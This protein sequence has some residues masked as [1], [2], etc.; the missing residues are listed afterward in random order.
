M[1]NINF[2]IDLGTTNSGIGLY[3]DGKVTVLKNPVGFRETLP[4]VVSF[5]GERILIGD[6]ANEQLFSNP[7]NVFSSF[8]RK[9]GT[10][11][12]YFVKALNKD[13]TPVELSTY[14]L[15]E[16][17]NFSINSGVDS[18]VI[19]IPASFDTIQSNATKTAGYQSGLS[20]VVLLQ[21][22]IAACLAYANENELN[23]TEEKKWLVYDFGGGTFDVAIVKVNERELKVLDNK[24]NNFLGG[25]DLDLKIM[26]DVVIP[27]LSQLT[28]IENLSDK[29][30]SATESEFLKLGK[31]LLYQ[32]EEIK[33]E[34]SLKKEAWL[35]VN[36]HELGINQELKITREEINKIIEPVY[37]ESFVLL[38]ELLDDN[39][40]LFSD[41]ERI[42][43]VGG[44]TYIPFIRDSLL[45]STGITIDSSIDPTTAVILGATYYAGNKPK[46]K[47]ITED[48]K[49]GLKTELSI[50][51]SYENLTKDE[52]ELIAFKTESPFEGFYRVV[53]SD[54]GF[55]SGMIK[56]SNHANEFV[57]LLTKQNN[58]FKLSIFDADQKSVY[59]NSEI[60]ISHGFYNVNG[61]PLPNDIC[62]E[63]DEEKETYLELIFKKN[64]IL[65]LKKTIYKTFSKSIAKGSDDKVVIN[66]VE[67]RA[68]SLPGANLNIGYVEISGKDL[69]DDLI[70][71]TDIELSFKISE[72]R[73][74]SVEIFIPSS[75]QE[76]IETF[77]PKYQNEIGSDKLISELNKGLNIVDEQIREFED[78]EDY[79]QLAFLTKIKDELGDVKGSALLF[80][81]GI[82]TD[83]KY[84]L[85]EKKRKLL[86][87]VDK[88]I[89]LQ[90]VS[91]EIEDYHTNKD[92]LLGQIDNF[93]PALKKDFDN[94]IK[95][96]KAFLK[97]GDKFLIRRKI[98]VFE[99]INQTLYLENDESYYSIFVQLKFMDESEFKNYS[100]VQKLFNE[101]EKAFEKNETK[102]LK[103]FCQLIFTYLKEDKKAK[104]SFS[105]TGLK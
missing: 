25:L 93:S 87:Q 38:E 67:G 9:M 48:V 49:E 78:S 91:S 68:G 85:M 11:E 56:F 43:L 90:G 53:R 8:K 44:T 45:N 89:F 13:I 86:F 101:G 5:R 17:Q 73:D 20:E 30:N 16:L 98:K 69:T 76:I 18:A 65:P 74:L 2:G 82:L 39:E 27:K 14:V 54:G 105:G 59:V 35:E 6:K 33:K 51:L 103:A 57:T 77:N 10:S 95:N 102:K 60:E 81:D 46:T 62:I 47:K 42:I 41:F 75:E 15:N 23:I 66:I 55:D 52:E 7:E 63:L 94:V 37:N 32:T 26:S 97:S 72:S 100:K 50:K 61:Q 80:N 92:Y 88:M 28:K 36:F 1:A 31:Y 58:Q 99:R 22:P 4:S 79:E 34:L 83:N 12:S 64:T 24:G 104:Q 71:G 21:E 40:L 29:I 3:K 70:K 84:Q 19:T 96:E